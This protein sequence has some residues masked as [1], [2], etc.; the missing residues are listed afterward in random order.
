M[1]GTSSSRR[2]LIRRA[3]WLRPLLLLVGL[4]NDANSYVAIEGERLRVRFG[5]FFN[6]TFPLSA[7]EGVAPMRWPWYHGLGWRTNLVG[8]VGWVASLRGVVQIRFLERQ[9]VGWIIPLVKLRCDRLAVSL[10]EPEAFI[11]ALNGALGR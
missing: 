1:R 11:A 4:T 6:Q 7:I 2:F 8:L 5:W 10:E 9:R 3:W